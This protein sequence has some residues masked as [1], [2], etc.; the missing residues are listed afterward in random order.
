[1]HATNKYSQHSSIIWPVWLN[2]WVFVFG[3]SGCLMH[4]TDKYSQHSS[5]FWPVWLNGRVFVYEL[6]GWGFES[7]CCY[8]ND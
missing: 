3:L 6:S 1:M 4:H 7:H 5:I 8:Y 2:G